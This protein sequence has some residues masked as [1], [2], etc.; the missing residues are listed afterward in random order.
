[1]QFEYTP[2]QTTFEEAFGGFN[3]INA[4]GPIAAGDDERFLDFLQKTQA[5][6]RTPIYINS[7]GGDVESS[8]NIGRMVR[9]SWLSTNVGQYILDEDLS[10]ELTKKRKLLPARC[11][12]AATL[13]YLGGRLRYL[14]QDSEFGVHQFSFRNP[15]PRHLAQS[16]ILSAKIARYIVEM[17]ITS[18]FLEISSATP[19]DEIEILSH[20][21]LERLGVVTGGQTP[22]TWSIQAVEGALY[23]RGERDNLFGH[24][25]MLLGF[26]KPRGFF[27]H[28]V[29]ESQGREQELM[30]F[31][32]VE[33]VIGDNDSETIDI[34]DRCDRK[35]NGIYANVSAYLDPEEARQ[36]A[37]SNAFGVRLRTTPDAPVFLGIGPMSTDG[38]GHLLQSFFLTLS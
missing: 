33:L 13:I 12:S 35:I 29:I 28:A 19:S 37:H 30:T 23:V 25:K 26:I 21:L 3:S 27:V 31:P 1:M 15:S 24:H 38:G 11:L 22:V 32:L 10:D 36:V 2:P 20:D 4:F 6:P 34:S 16:Q 9:D 8:I 18:E 7:T 5:P 17:G 14:N